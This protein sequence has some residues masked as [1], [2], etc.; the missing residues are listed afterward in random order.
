M[1][2]AWRAV[3]PSPPV[4]CYGRPSTWADAEPRSNDDAPAEGAR[5]ELEVSAS[6]PCPPVSRAGMT[7]SAH[8]ATRTSGPVSTA[9]EERMLGF[10]NA[11]EVQDFTTAALSHQGEAGGAQRAVTLGANARNQGLPG[12]G[13]SAFHPALALPRLSASP[14][15]GL[16]A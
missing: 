9:V 5:P 16:A 11:I 13:H 2:R 7:A 6:D 4:E 12:H 14:S 3:L 8:A 10:A 1:D 15:K